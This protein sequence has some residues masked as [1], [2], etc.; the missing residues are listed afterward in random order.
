[1]PVPRAVVER[2]LPFDGGGGEGGEE[3]GLEGGRG[4]EG[5]RGGGREGGRPAFGL[6]EESASCW[7]EVAW[8]YIFLLLLFMPSLPPSLPPS[9]L[10]PSLLLLR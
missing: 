3:V 2:S 8:S 10:L 4:R 7:C 6:G 5:G 1:M 9:L